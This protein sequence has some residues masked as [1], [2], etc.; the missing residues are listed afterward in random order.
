MGKPYKRADGRYACD[1]YVSGKK[2]TV[3]GRTAR[4]AQQNADELRKEHAKGRDVTQRQIK[5]GDFLD[6]WLP[7]VQ[8]V[9]RPR[10]YAETRNIIRNHLK[11]HLGHIWLNK[12]VPA[13]IQRMV[14]K[15]NVELAPKTVQNIVARLR[16]AL[17]HAVHLR[18][19]TYNPAQHATLPRMK[20]YKPQVLTPEQ[21][22]ALLDAARGTEWYV[23]FR[24]VLELGLRE[25]EL[26]GLLKADVKDN[27]TL[28]LSGSLHRID[29]QNVWVEGTKNGEIA[30]M[31]LSD[32]LARLL[33]EQCKVRPESE[34]LFTRENGE[35]MTNNQVIWHFR[36]IAGIAG[37]PR[38]RFHDLR[39]TSASFLIL[40]G[41][42]PRMVMEHLRH[43]TI[44][45][46]MDIYG[47][48][49]PSEHRRAS[50]Q[51]SASLNPQNPAPLSEPPSKAEE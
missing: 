44:A 36:K 4:E 37:V 12:L 45:T 11:P 17:F 5:V 25:S 18:L 19:I 21:A 22:R 49:F 2:K 47:H 42:H 13:D 40:Q 50:E 10:T 3:Y 26:L 16:R 39:H 1:V 20:K 41:E 15:L 27:Q 14:D 29:G 9:N 24:T 34:Y 31:P 46:T 7:I 51:L 30:T 8:S 35:P 48:I 32:E 38:V 6:S 23:V 43:S 33:R 28:T